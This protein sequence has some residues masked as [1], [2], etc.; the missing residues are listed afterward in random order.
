M[1]GSAGT[2]VAAALKYAQRLD[3]DQLVVV[4]LPDT[5]RNYL[6]KIFSDRW[7]E[8]NGF[9]LEGRTRVSVADV[10]RSKA[11]PGELIFVR[12]SDAPIRAAEIMQRTGFSQLPVVD[13]DD[14]VGGLNEVT[15]AKLLYD[16]VDLSMGTVAQVMGKAAPVLDADVEALGQPWSWIIPSPARI[17]S[18]PS[19][20]GPTWFCTA[21]QSTSMGTAM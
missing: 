8:L 4:V 2:A 9:L 7:M 19:I 16:G 12:P 6:T 10:V 14:V 3:R 13:G 11:N 20:L 21:P 18:N 5:G 15:L 1:G 17:S